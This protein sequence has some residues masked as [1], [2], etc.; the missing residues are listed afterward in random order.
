MPIVAIREGCSSIPK[1]FMHP[2]F[3]S[4]TTYMRGKM[5]ETTMDALEEKTVQAVGRASGT[6]KG[7]RING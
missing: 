3:D 5:R 2:A 6:A 7:D 4:L 1:E